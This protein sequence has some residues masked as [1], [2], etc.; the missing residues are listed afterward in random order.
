MA[1]RV[2][3]ATCSFTPLGV[4]G[5]RWEDDDERQE[6][7]HTASAHTT[8]LPDDAAPHRHHHGWKHSRQH[9]NGTEA[10]C[11]SHRMMISPA[12]KNHE[13][14]PRGS[15]QQ[16]RVATT[17]YSIKSSSLCEYSGLARSNHRKQKEKFWQSG[18]GCVSLSQLIHHRAMHAW[19]PAYMHHDMDW[20][21][22]LFLGLRQ[23]VGS[24]IK[25]KDWSQYS[26]ENWRKAERILTSN[27]GDKAEPKPL[28]INWCRRR[29][30]KLSVDPIFQH[31]HQMIHKMDGGFLFERQSL[32]GIDGISFEWKGSK[33]LR[34]SITRS[35]RERVTVEIRRSCLS[36][37]RRKTK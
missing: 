28:V 29:L 22:V 21:W 18:E 14:Q 15:K 27:G 36:F 9:N 25:T 23:K 35:L 16:N 5:A 33:L 7:S 30:K 2:S 11:W 3:L 34:L 1:F 32:D 31:S 4:L 20:C 13:M 37:L 19:H 24:T 17:H 10:A 12:F 8:H 6:G 26:S